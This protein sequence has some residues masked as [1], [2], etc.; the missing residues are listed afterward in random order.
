MDFGVLVWE[1]FGRPQA[2]EQNGEL[3]G[4]VRMECKLRGLEKSLLLFGR[5]C[6]GFWPLNLLF[7]CSATGRRSRVAGRV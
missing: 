6:L 3:K 1:V 7:L 2:I 5:L 4:E